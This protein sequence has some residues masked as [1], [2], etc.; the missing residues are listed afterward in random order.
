MRATDH[1]VEQSCI[2]A[3]RPLA[4]NSPGNHLIF[5]VKVIPDQIDDVRV[6]A[7]VDGRHHGV[8]GE[9]EKATVTR[10]WRSV[11]RRLAVGGRFATPDG[12]VG[13]ERAKEVLILTEEVEML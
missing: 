10:K 4:A 1:E 5:I 3:G 2:S 9:W 11:A 13:V 7:M 12:A 6:V 8:E